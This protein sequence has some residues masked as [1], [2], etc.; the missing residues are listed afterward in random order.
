VIEI[1]YDVGTPE[2]ELRVMFDLEVDD[3]DIVTA[4]GEPWLARGLE[5]PRRSV[6]QLRADA[7]ASFFDHASQPAAQRVLSLREAAPHLDLS[8][9]QLRHD[10]DQGRYDAGLTE[11]RQGLRA[12]RFAETVRTW[13]LPRARMPDPRVLAWLEQTGRLR[14]IEPGEEFAPDYT[15]RADG[16]A[17]KAKW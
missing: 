13:R 3:E 7:L 9:R 6:K 12:L 4:H 11:T 14:R 8:E 17:W 5:P 1:T 15:R 16:E 2:A 10:V